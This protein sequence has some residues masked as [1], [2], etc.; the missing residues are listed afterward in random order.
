[1]FANSHTNPN[2]IINTFLFLY[3]LYNIHNLRIFFLHFS[4][5]MHHFACFFKTSRKLNWYI[6]KTFPSHN[7]CSFIQG[8]KFVLNP[9]FTVSDVIS[10]SL[11]AYTMYRYVRN[12]YYYHCT[13]CIIGGGT[14]SKIIII[15]II[16]VGGDLSNSGKRSAPAHDGTTATRTYT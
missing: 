13:Y 14:V 6:F 2:W 15:I 7:L 16:T 9:G 5:E 3:Y 1:M 12:N 8:R 4:T 10:L 11:Y